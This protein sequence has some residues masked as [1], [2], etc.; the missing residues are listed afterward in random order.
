[1][2]GIVSDST[3]LAGRTM[4]VVLF[5]T[6]YSSMLRYA[7]LI[8]KENYARAI[9]PFMSQFYPGFSATWSADYQLYKLG[10]LRLLKSSDLQDFGAV[11]QPFMNSLRDHLSTAKVLVP[12]GPSLLRQIEHA[13]GKEVSVGDQERFVYDSLFLVRRTP[14]SH[15][16]LIAQLRTRIAMLYGD[17][18]LAAGSASGDSILDSLRRVLVAIDREFESTV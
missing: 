7:R 6:A 1:M 16:D 13:H 10:I 2:D 11:K 3:E 18:L 9:R 4:R 14:L 5:T 17:P 8:G 15:G 12:D